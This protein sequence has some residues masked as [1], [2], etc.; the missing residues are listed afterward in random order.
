MKRALLGLIILCLIGLMAFTLFRNKSVADLKAKNANHQI[1]I[2][3]SAMAVR[4]QNLQSTFSKTGTIV[5]NNEVT[6]VSQT[7]GKVI[8]IYVNVGSQV[9]AGSP[10]AKVEDL[11]LK[12]KLS[13]ARTAYMVAE[14]D[15][16]RYRQLHDEK[17]I[18]D[19]DLESSQKTLQAAKADLDIAQ[20]DYNNSLITAPVSGVISNR[21][22]DL[23]A[24]VTSGTTIATIVDNSS[25]KMTV[26]VN[27]EQAF[28]FNIGD[29]VTIET[30]VY[31][32]VKLEGR[33]KSISTKSDAV[34]TFPVEITILSDKAHP[35]KSGIFGKVTFDLGGTTNVL[36][37]PREALIGSIKT[38]QVYVVKNGRA[39][40]RDIV[41]DSEI[42]SY[43]VI[44][45]GINEND[46]IVING[47]EN[48]TNHAAVKIIQQ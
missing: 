30:N 3:V 21:A 33:I 5:A 16:E 15:W 20:D 22:V 10:I 6:I 11:V 29:L 9:R 12:S 31:P 17:I 1:L 24:T 23:G 13:S 42:N 28:K 18:S 27:E 38:P 45:S 44:K 47:Q 36:A 25:F 2:P 7:S 4:K 37:I 26:N 32:N 19:S 40:L 39:I 34:H 48:L 46:S 41:I 43:L 8:G 14:K 35:L